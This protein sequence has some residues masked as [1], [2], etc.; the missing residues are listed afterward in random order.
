[1]GQYT[2]G[3]N[4]LI[5]KLID[6]A[7]HTDIVHHIPGRIRLKVGFSGLLL[8]RDLDA[9]DLMKHFNGI[10]DAR[11]NAPARSIVIGYD[12]RVIDPDFWNHL[13]DLR[14]NPEL[15]RSV[16]KELE[17]LSRREPC[18][19]EQRLDLEN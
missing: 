1:M 3:K 15:R 7:A 18:D 10:L 19:S 12:K 9:A 17:R 16:E 11:V 5:D 14:S 8:A 6:L 13:I 4:I 2:T